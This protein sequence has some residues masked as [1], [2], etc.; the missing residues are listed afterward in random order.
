MDIFVIGWGKVGS[1][2]SAFL[3][4]RGL[5]HE[6]LHEA[7]ENAKGIL[8][9]AVSDS[10][11]APLLDEIVE[12]NQELFIVHFSAATHFVHNRVFLLHPFSSVNKNSDLSKILFTL[13]GEKNSVFEEMLG[14]LGLKF[15]FCGET[16]GLLYHSAAVISGN[17]T[18]FFVLKALELLGSSGFS[19]E[20][21]ERLIR[22][23][24]DSSLDNVFRDGVKGLTGPA[25]RGDS[26]VLSNEINALSEK[27]EELAKL[28]KAVN[29]AVSRASKTDKT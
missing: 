21:S 20:D 19:R 4:N 27:D 22:Q 24:V 28:F 9:L 1:A 12:R 6:I 8:F 17:F 23:L 5:A 16:P 18:Q 2:L 7:P 25:V 26:E 14:R 3:K 11:V 10:A 15:V 29:E 13:W